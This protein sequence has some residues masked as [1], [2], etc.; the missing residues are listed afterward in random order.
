MPLNSGIEPP[1]PRIRAVRIVDMSTSNPWPE[2]ALVFRTTRSAFLE[3]E[4]VTSELKSVIPEECQRG[5][6]RSNWGQALCRRIETRSWNRHMFI[7]DLTLRPRPAPSTV[8]IRLVGDDAKAKHFPDWRASAMNKYAAAR[9]FL[10]VLAPGLAFAQGTEAVNVLDANAKPMATLLVP[11]RG[12][13]PAEVAV[14]INDNDPQSVEVA[15]YYQQKRHIPDQNMIHLNF[16]Q[17]KL[18]EGF[19]ANNGLD[20]KEFA[21]L[22][23]QVDAAAGTQIQAQ[24]IT[25]SKPFRIASFNYYPTNYSITSAFTFGI[26]S[27]YIGIP[28]CNPMPASP[29]YNSSSSKPYTD[30]H[31]RPTMMLAGVDTASVKATIDKGAKADGSFPAGTGWFARTADAAR[32]DPRFAD[33]KSTVQDWNRPGAL[34]MKYVDYSAGGSANI[35]HRS[36]ILF[37]ETGAVNVP[38]L[39]T[40][41]YV[42]GALADHLTSGGGDLFGSTAVD[43]GQMSILRWLEAGA[44]AS[45]GTETEPC[46]HAQKFPQASVLVKSYFVGDTAVEAYLKSVQWPAQGVFVGEP[47]ARPFGTKATLDD[48]ALTI[49]TTSLEPGVTY[50]LSSAPARA[51]PF[52]QVKTVS[53]PNYQSVTIT[54]EG[55]PAPFYKLEEATASKDRPAR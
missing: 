53:V 29:Y 43:N 51:G 21:L 47:L 48:G 16:D 55:M 20:P 27:G 33:F 2:L 5:H 17:N 23:A 28:S 35:A 44:T 46:A 37:Y 15:S 54:V 8:R 12:I 38:S 40:N 6:W 14:L 49:T 4:R 24:V 42:P 9:V 41:T 36:N 34:S 22:K 13:S 10:F 11:R 7:G 18:Y 25:W 3:H 1:R 45:Y 31:I 39:R 50:A 30:F 19:T 32:S 26:D 52:T